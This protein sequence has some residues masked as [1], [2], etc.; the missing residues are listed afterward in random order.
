MERNHETEPGWYLLDSSSRFENPQATGSWKSDIHGF[1]QRDFGERAAG[2]SCF[3]AGL[4]Q[5]AR[6]LCVEWVDCC[7]VNCGSPGLIATDMFSVH[8]E[9]RRQKWFQMIPTQRL[10]DP[11]E[12]KA[13]RKCVWCSYEVR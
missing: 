11:P 9:R 2:Q 12:L 7:R 13:V 6:F 10:R 8:P 4:V 3:K 1:N 5:P